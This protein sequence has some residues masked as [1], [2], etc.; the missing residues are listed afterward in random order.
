[1]NMN[2][3]IKKPYTFNWN[4]SFLQSNRKINIVILMQ[5]LWETLTTTTT[6][7]SRINLRIKYASDIVSQATTIENCTPLFD[8]NR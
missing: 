6:T 3:N 5:M 4:K 8:Q 7:T 1:M 2:V